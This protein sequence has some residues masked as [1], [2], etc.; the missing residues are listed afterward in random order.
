MI[1]A[2]VNMCNLQLTVTLC[3]YFLLFYLLLTEHPENVV[4]RCSHLT[5][6]DLAGSER[7]DSSSKQSE[8][9]VARQET[10]NINKSIYALGNCIQALSR[11]TKQR[12]KAGSVSKLQPHVPYR[13]SKLTRLLA[14]PMSRS[15]TRTCIVCTISPMLHGFAESVCSLTFAN[16]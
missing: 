8:S 11:N 4:T 2:L 7:F 10:Q 13:D 1:V 12:G 16:R 15:Q 3:L 5:L 6:C 14:D 9:G